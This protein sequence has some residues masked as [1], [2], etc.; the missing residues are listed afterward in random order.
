M[1][2]T[3]RHPALWRFLRAGGERNGVNALCN[4]GRRHRR[5]MVPDRR[6]ASVH[7]LL[8]YNHRCPWGNSQGLHAGNGLERYLLQ[9]S[10]AQNLYRVQQCRGPLQRGHQRITRLGGNGSRIGWRQPM[11]DPFRNNYQQLFRRIRQAK[12]AGRRARHPGRRQT[13]SSRCFHV[14]RVWLSIQH[15]SSRQCSARLPGLQ[16]S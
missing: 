11:H 8:E 7:N 10:P 12:L 1:H 4:G 16:F 14:R 2:L 9:S 13:R 3:K 15:R 5:A 6:H